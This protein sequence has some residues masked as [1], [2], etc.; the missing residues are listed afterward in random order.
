MKNKVFSLLTLAT[1]G[2]IL[3]AC[4][5]E[6]TLSYTRPWSRAEFKEEFKKPTE[7]NVYINENGQIIKINDPDDPN[8]NVLDELRM[9]Q[10]VASLYY[11]DA[12]G[13]SAFNETKQLSV[14]GYPLK[15][16]V[17][18][19]TWSS[20]D[21]A[22]ASVS[23]DGLVTALKEGVAIITATS[24]AGKTASCRIV[25]NNTN[26]LLST[27]SKSAKKILETQKSSDFEPVTT[28]SMFEEYT[29][30]KT[31]DGVELARS[32]WDQKMWASINDAYFRITSND[33]DVKTSGGSVVPSSTAYVFYTTRDYISYV[34]CNS[35]GKSNYM[36]LD[37]AFLVDQGKTPFEGLSEILQSFFVAGAGIMTRQF[38]DILGQKQ[39]DNG[40]GSPKYKGSF[41]ENSGQFAFN[42]ITS[43][44]GKISAEDEKDMGI[45]AGTMVQITDDIRYLWEDNLLSAKLLTE[46]LTYE[47][48]GHSYEEVYAINYNFKGRGVELWWPEMANYSLVDS[49]F[50]L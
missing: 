21:S 9:S 17:G 46:T 37:Q 38:T 33:E 8:V 6:Q 34:F 40:Y 32:K 22:V 36:S 2:S 25:V 18:T 5:K 44:G 12:K 28:L 39:L 35:N 3:G 49:I 48:D 11:S 1:I 20:S 50:D 26:V 41:G 10:S 13:S 31:R 43:N 42:Q 15:A 29:S 7:S 45:P 27:V 47:L 19:V 14:T 16:P 24:E 23:A 4:T 30:R